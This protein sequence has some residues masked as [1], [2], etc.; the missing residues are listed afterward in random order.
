LRYSQRD[1]ATAAF[2][3]C[4]F[5]IWGTVAN[6][7]PFVRTNLNDSFLL[8]LMFVISAA[9]PS[10]VLSADVAVRKQA[11]AR[12]ALLV[13]E[14]QHRSKNLLAV[15]QSIVNNTMAHSPDTANLG[16]IIGGR[17][18]ALAR[19]QDYLVSGSEERSGDA[20]SRRRRVGALRLAHSHGRHGPR[21]R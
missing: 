11:Q 7:G 3:L 2:L 9:V 19:A 1:T 17:L 8:V 10:L 13:R 12:Q 4:C 20:R 14:L 6:G 18:Q 16:D 15:V 5:A 21:Y